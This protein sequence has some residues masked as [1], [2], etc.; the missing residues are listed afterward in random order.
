LF[1]ESLE[2]GVN[3]YLLKDK[4]ATDIIA[5]MRTVLRGDTYICPTMSTHLVRRLKSSAKIS[6]RVPGL[7]D[8]TATE[9]SILK[10]IAT[11]KTSPGSN[12]CV[13]SAG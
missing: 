5:A 7:Q 4:A 13:S 2:S 9:R 1:H 12:R 10:L 3:G 6:Q 8:L 11:G